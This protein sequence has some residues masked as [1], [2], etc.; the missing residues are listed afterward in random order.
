[1]ALITHDANPVII[2]FIKALLGAVFLWVITLFLKKQYTKNN[3]DYTFL[4]RCLK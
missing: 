4:L 2:S 1:M 3:M